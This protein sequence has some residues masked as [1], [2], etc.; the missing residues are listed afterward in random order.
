[1][2]LQDPYDTPR[3]PLVGPA[4]RPRG[5]WFATAILGPL[6][7]ANL[8]LA[9][10]WLH[11]GIGEPLNPGSDHRP[12]AGL[13]SLLV[14]IAGSL[15]MATLGVAAIGRWHRGGWK[16]ARWAAIGYLSLAAM[17]AAGIWLVAE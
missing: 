17:A 7:L 2:G 16:R 11:L 5:R 10:G 9:A 1:M 13:W 15:V 3:S 12:P 4:D 14:L 8:G 6:V